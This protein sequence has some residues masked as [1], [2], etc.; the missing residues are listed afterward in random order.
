MDKDKGMEA[1]N[2]ADIRRNTCRMDASNIKN[3]GKIM[4]AS[5]SRANNK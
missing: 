4:D 2:R 3:K 1:S 5:N